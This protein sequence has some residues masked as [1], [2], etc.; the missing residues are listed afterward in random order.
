MTFGLSNVFGIA[1]DILIAGLD[2]LGR[3]CDETVDIILQI[4]KKASFKLRFISI[5]FQREDILWDAVGP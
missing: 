3:D 1:E 2:K 4:C 5:P